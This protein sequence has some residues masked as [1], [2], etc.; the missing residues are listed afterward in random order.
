MTPILAEP[1]QEKLDSRQQFLDSYA[2][3]VK[4]YQEL[5]PLESRVSSYEEKLQKIKSKPHK[6][7]EDILEVRIIQR[8][9]DRA[10][11]LHEKLNR[12]PE[13]I[14]KLRG[15]DTGA[16]ELSVLDGEIKPLIEAEK[17]KAEFH[18]DKSQMEVER[19]VAANA[20]EAAKRAEGKI[21]E[22]RDEIN[23]SSGVDD[24]VR[25]LS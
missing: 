14:R 24:L 6:T 19:R 2:S 20:I 3:I 15:K 7:Q 12:I 22:L 13:E 18:M 23:K 11:E 10:S 5:V 8:E 16:V 17:F 9:V 25:H 4:I 1:K 21:N